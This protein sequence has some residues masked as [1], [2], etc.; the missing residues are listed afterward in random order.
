MA[1]IFKK[2]LKNIIN[3]Y[4]YVDKYYNI[5]NYLCHII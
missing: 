3:A 4:V 1:K 2:I 5:L